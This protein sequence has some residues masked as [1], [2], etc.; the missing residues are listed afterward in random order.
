MRNDGLDDFRGLM[1][2]LVRPA[3]PPHTGRPASFNEA[4]LRRP[5]GVITQIALLGSGVWH[6]ADSSN[7]LGMRTVCGLIRPDHR[8][9]YRYDV[10]LGDGEG[11]GRCE[12]LAWRKP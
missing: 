2:D 3:T 10:L 1:G 9:N 12:A 4:N 8:L 7:G 5:R 11:C 6:R